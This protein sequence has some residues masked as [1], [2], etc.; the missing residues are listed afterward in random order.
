[1]T[2]VQTQDTAFTTQ[3]MATKNIQ[4]WSWTKLR[5][6]NNKEKT[7]VKPATFREFES[8]VELKTNEERAKL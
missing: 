8:N 6:R 3:T 1:M 4:I 7:Y 5:L 2:K